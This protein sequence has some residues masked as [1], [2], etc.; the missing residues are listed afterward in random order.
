MDFTLCFQNSVVTLIPSVFLM[1][2]I[3]PRLLTVVGKGRLEGVKVTPV[4]VVKMLTTL[5]AFAVQLGILIKVI[6]DNDLYGG[7]S[8]LS[9]AVYLAGLAGALLL[10]WFEHYNMPNPSSSLLLFW[11]LT[12]LLSIFPTRSWIQTTPD[13][14]SATLPTLK[15]VFSILALFAFILENI[16]K[17]N[18][19][20]LVR[21]GGVPVPEQSNPSPEPHSNYFKRLTFFW[22]FP[23]LRLGKS[24]TLKMDDLYNLNPKLL[25]Y[26]LYLTTTAKLHADE[27]IALDNKAQDAAA[28]KKSQEAGDTTKVATR[29]T[30]KI[31]LS[32]TIFHTVGYTFMTAAI[33]RVFY[34]VCYY[35][36]PIL[37]SELVAFVSSYSPASKARGIEPLAPWIGFGYVIAVVAASILSSLFDGQF[38]FINY[39][40]GLKARSVFVTLVY[41]KSLRLSST[42]K[43]EGM[44]SIVNHMS[45]DVDKVVAFFDI[46]HLLWSALVEVI[47]TIAMLYKEVRYTI[48]AS[49]GVV[50]VMIIIVGICSPAVGKNQKASMKASDHRMK[51]ITE[52]VGAIKSIKLYGWEEYFVKK[53]TTARNEQLMYLRR[54]FSWITAVVTVINMIHPFVIFVTLAVYSSVAPADAPLDIRRIFTTITLIGMLEDPVGLLS[55]SM[56]AIVTGQ[57]AYGRLSGFLNSEEIDETNVIKNP[58]A[59]ASEI[60]FEVTNGTFGWYTP[61]AIDAAI[62]KK[63]KE[64]EKKA[65]EE[66]KKNK[67]NKKAPVAPATA[68]LESSTTLDEKSDPTVTDEKAAHTASETL[69]ATR[70]SMGPVMHDINLQIRRGALTAIVGR[71]GEGKSSLVG[72]LLGEMYKYSGQVRSFGSLA[73]VSQTAWI[74]NATVR[75]NILFGRPF[76]KERYLETI[77][78]CALVPDFK[79]LVSGDKTVIGEK[80][81]NLSG[82]Q[83]QR[84]S[85]ARA[86]YANADV[87]ILDDPLSAVDAHVDHHIFKHAL[88]TILADKTRILVTNGVNHLKEVDQIIVIKQGRITQD[89]AY[90]D[91]IQN[92]DGDLYRLIQESKLVASKEDN[93]PSSSSSVSEASESELEEDKASIVASISEKESLPTF[94]TDRPAGPVKRPTFK[95]AKSSKANKQGDDDHH[96]EID[97]KNEVDEEITT[98]G[99]VGWEVYK[100]YITSIGIVSCTIFL[101]STL[102]NLAVLVGTQLWLERW[103]NSTEMAAAGLAP[104]SHSDTYWVVSYFAW[105]L[106]GGITL[107]GAIGLSMIV[108]AQRGSHFLHAAMLRPLVRAPMSFFDITSSG[109]IVNRF[110]HDINAVDIELP[111]Q[112]VNMLFIST[113]AISIFVF[114]ILATRW[115]FAI[116]VPLGICYYIL[117]G[118]FLVSSRELKRLDSAAR[119]PMYAHFG[120]TLAGLVTIR[121]FNDTE[122]LAI[123]ATTLLDRS[124]TTGY[125]TNMTNR[126]LQIMIDQLSTLTLGF[127][128]LMAVVQREGSAGNFAIMLSNIGVLTLI[129]SRILSTSCLIQTSIVSVERVR[130]YSNLTPE[131]RDVIPDSKTD[132]AWPQNGAIELKDY[133]VRYREG[134]DLVLKDVSVKIQPGERV[135]IVGR[136]GA[137]KSSVTLGLFRIIEAATGSITI[138]GIDISTLGLHELRS[139][140]TIIPQEPFLFG[141]TI[142]L[143]LDPF[144]SHTDAEIWSALESASLKPYIT[145]LSEGLSTVIENGGEN[146]SLGQRQLMS[147]ARAMLAK[148]TRVLCLDEATAAIDVETDNAIQRALRREFQNCTVLTIAHRINTI[149]DSDKILVLDQGRVAEF[150]SPTNLLEKKDGLFYGLA[151]QSGNV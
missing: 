125:L 103:G 70:D 94:T 124:Q 82:G 28:V 41:R 2:F 92:V 8:I 11:L 35:I 109:K 112:F 29:I 30:P 141:D 45:T 84:I 145:T 100:Y 126:W 33:P 77:R 149:M 87:Y 57:V 134:L 4:F 76:D 130:E 44:G 105:V 58:D 67:K 85:I 73:Y 128:C 59:T 75:E 21:S 81:I 133:S 118:F 31:N 113:M 5:A 99:R 88:T 114:C 42:N 20:S 40:A 104:E 146:M 48:F 83:K 62:E 139:R 53:I 78:S 71:V 89:G 51:L 17:P 135:G 27:A 15:L 18:Y 26:P 47:I 56:S 119:S 36:R 74:L 107:A 129:M 61:E 69:P 97:E 98:E 68:E 151:A 32:G 115:F 9:S 102:V 1:I 23:L 132:P 25:S 54:F 150:D 140:L 46:I 101:L 13:G 24:R 49:L 131:A 14:L 55:S 39:N 143:N 10:H 96:L 137:G 72:A 66:A 116:M 64:D 80:G 138:D 90:E 127:V 95:R 6:S 12:T 121:A 7:S 43:Q 60:A 122:R 136:T 38:Q 50:V 93:A 123:Q 16:P 37:F 63:A 22:L 106:A 108:M 79:M 86:V 120:E 19:K 110:S 117:G 148:S 147:L 3:S 34:I 65:K 144:S 91:L 52:L 142:R 111:L